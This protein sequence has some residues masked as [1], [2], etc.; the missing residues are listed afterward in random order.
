[1]SKQRDHGQTTRVMKAGRAVTMI[2]L[3]ALTITAM[4]GPDDGRSWTLTETTIRIGTGSGVDIRLTDPAVSRR[5]AR[6]VQAQDG[7]RLVDE[8]SRNG[9]WVQGMRIAEVYLQDPMEFTLGDTRL[10]VRS[11]DKHY[12]AALRTDSIYGRLV[13]TS[14]AIRE[15]HG[16]IESIAASSVTILILGESGTGKEVTARCIHERSQREGPYVVFD[17]A[18]TGSDLIRSELFGHRTG[19]FTGADNDRQGAFLSADRGTLF[20]DEI[21]ELPLDLQPTLLRVLETREVKPLGMDRPRAVDVRVVTATHRNLQQ[22][23]KKGTFRED[24]YHRLA[25]VPLRLPPLRERPE[26]MSLLVQHFVES[27]GLG[28][29]FTDE[30]IQFLAQQPWEGNIRALRNTLERTCL[31]TPG[32]SIEPRDIRLPLTGAEAVGDAAQAPWRVFPKE[33]PHA[34]G[35][36]PTQNLAALERQAIEEALAAAG[37]RKVDAARLLGIDVSTLRRKLKLQG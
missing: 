29:T 25:V 24:L 20:I 35:S 16:I 36:V 17:C 7:P 12:Y 3:P 9:T 32:G 22:M 1:M 4:S 19:A 18:S 8:E 21:G 33:E 14:E 28:K 30:A 26:D 2:R 37:G 27:L 31:L 5:H 34:P 10:A 11:R 13:G 6:I 15:V 23:V